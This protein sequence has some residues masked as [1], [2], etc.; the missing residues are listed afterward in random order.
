MAVNKKK[1]AKKKARKGRKK[2]RAKKGRK[3]LRGK[4]V[5]NAK[6]K[7]EFEIDEVTEVNETTKKLKLKKSR[8]RFKKNGKHDTSEE[9]LFF[10]P[11]DIDEILKNKKMFNP[12]KVIFNDNG[13]RILEEM[14]E[15]ESAD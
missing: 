6:G 12:S 13:L 7:F 15:E 3:V 5:K 8:K 11:D 9:E 10:L 2:V 14:R 1:A 4:K